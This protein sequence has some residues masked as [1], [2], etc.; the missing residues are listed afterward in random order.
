MIQ[1]AVYNRPEL[2]EVEYKKRINVR[3]ADAA[4]LEMLPGIQIYAGS[5]ADSNDFL[6]HNDWVNWGAKA[7]WNLLKIFS[8]RDRK[9][10]IERQDDMLGQRSLALTMAVMTQVHVSR[11]RFLHEQKELRTAAEYRDVQRRL[12]EQMRAEHA[13]DR[14]SKQT[15]IREEM[16]T[17]VAEAKYDMA[18][19]MLQNAYAN[20]FSSMGLDPY[21]WEVN[22][23]QDVASLSASL[24]QLWFERGDLGA[25]WS[26]RLASAE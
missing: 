26:K 6:L 18:Y 13:A 12:L 24:K 22:R 19:A 14:I 2:R 17:L 20:L 10:L 4:L 15:L 25:G 1:T 21:A 7:S 16:N 8:Y 23:D 9:D 3:E 11:I 5:N